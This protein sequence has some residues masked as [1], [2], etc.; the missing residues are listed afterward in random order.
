MVGTHCDELDVISLFCCFCVA[1]EFP[2]V[3]AAAGAMSGGGEDPHVEQA[4]QPMQGMQQQAMTGPCA[5]DKEMFY[6]CLQ[7]NRGDQQACSFLYDQL[8]MCQTSQP[9]FG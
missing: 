6:E 2:A 7:M 5:Q 3:G 4:Q 8:K 9:Q 1:L